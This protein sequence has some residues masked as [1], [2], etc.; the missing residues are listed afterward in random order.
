MIIAINYSDDNYEYARKY[1]T[2]TAYSV[3]EVN[4]VIEY[5]PKD[6]DSDFQKK[7]EAIL[8][9]KRGAGLWLWKPY[10]IKKTLEESNDGDYI[11][12]TDA[13][14]YFCNK[15][16]YLIDTLDR[17]GQ[18]VMGFGIPFL[19]RQ[20]TKKEAF[21][22][23]NDSI[24]DRNQVCGGY[25]LLKKDDFSMQFVREWLNFATDERII[26]PEH[27][28][29]D[30]DEFEDYVAHREDQ[31]V[32][33]ILYHK[34]GLKDFRDPSQ[35]GDRPWEYSCTKIYEVLFGKKWTYK[36]IKFKKEYSSYP[37]I[38]VSCRAIDPIIFKKMEKKRHLL[39][40]IGLFNKCTFHLWSYLAYLK[41]TKLKQNGN[42]HS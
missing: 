10:I 30:V 13:G 3:G 12:Y 38:V 25:V 8:S 4:K 22:L 16:Q 40:R 24:Y 7:Y 31:S 6:I 32:F 9:Y 27:F 17:S 21:V 29:S 20:F 39:Y 2:E 14:S 28:C 37:R 19:E 18:S 23:M 11:F 33:S 35:F 42:H 36:P 5:S 1:N 41:T 26:S 15:V 34:K